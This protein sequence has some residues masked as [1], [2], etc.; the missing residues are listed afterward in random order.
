M[1]LEA[2]FEVFNSFN[3]ED[4]LYQNLCRTFVFVYE[5]LSLTSNFLGDLHQLP[6]IYDSIVTENSSMDGR[7]SCAPS[8]WKEHFKIHYLTEKMR[9][10]ADPEFADLCDR[11]KEG[12]QSKEDIEFLNSRIR[13][14]PSEMFNENFKN[15]KL[16]IIVTTNDKKNLI[17]QEKLENLL[18]SEKEYNCNSIDRVVNLPA[19]TDLPKSTRRNP[20]KTGN[21][22]TLLKLKVNCPVVITSNHP[23][24]KY[25]EDGI[26]NGAR[27]FVQAV[28][29]SKDDPEKVDIVWVVFHDE[30]IGK[31]YR[32]EHAHFR[33][34]FNP[35][36]KLAT[37]I[38]PV[39]NNFNHG[40]VEYQR[41]NFPP[42][43]SYA[44]TAHKC[45]GWT[46][47]EVIVDFGSDLDL[48]LKAFIVPG[49]FYVAISRVRE[50]RN[51]YLKSFD[52][53]YIQV[54][55]RIVEIV[56]AMIK[57]SPYQFKKI[58]LDDEIFEDTSNEIKVG[59]LNIN[60]LLEGNHLNYFDSDR[61]L[62]NLQIMVL[63]ETKLLSSLNSVSIENKLKNWTIV[64]RFDA[65][66]G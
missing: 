60:G 22:Q 13:E 44:I 49:G 38:L 43:L 10:Q 5:S 28:Q 46:L 11:V 4:L 12:K 29:V 6:P 48:K 59:Y 52:P 58:Y 8:L 1:I 25:R 62:N 39:R 30:S 31:L 40:N 2:N 15:G 53:S 47:D 50:G 20:G 57:Q 3:F 64:D 56:N 7:P 26:I 33:S 24:K 23:K 17:N 37:P 21:L 19:G 16:S 36:H 66:S 42:S 45:Q 34:N 35:G 51:L 32:F 18:P 54:N 9:S 27:G 61:N 41:Q 65:Y 63:S 55:H 14:C